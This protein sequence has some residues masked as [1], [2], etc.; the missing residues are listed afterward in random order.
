VL[1]ISLF[2]PE[3]APSLIFLS[4]V[5]VTNLLG[6]LML[7][8]GWRWKTKRGGGWDV[9]R[10]KI[11]QRHR[12]ERGVEDAYTTYLGFLDL[13]TVTPHTGFVS[14][15]QRLALLTGFFRWWPEEAFIPDRLGLWAGATSAHSSEPR[16]RVWRFSRTYGFRPFG[17][18]G[19][20]SVFWTGT[21]GDADREATELEAWDLRGMVWAAPSSDV[22]PL[23]RT[24]NPGRTPWLVVMLEWE[25]KQRERERERERRTL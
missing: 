21:S 9:A 23:T 25:E 13:E 19:L 24:L 15:D 6:P 1:A 4:L 22:G 18:S 20:T 7:W 8:Y 10:V 16:V 12:W 5:A 2:P 11:R 17:L 3:P 14:L